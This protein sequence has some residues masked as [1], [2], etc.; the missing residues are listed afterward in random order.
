MIRLLSIV[1]LL[2]ALSSRSQ[3][4]LPKT[5]ADSLWKVWINT[6][7]HDTNRL[8]AIHKYTRE[9]FLYNQPDSALYFAGLQYEFAKKKRLKK[10]MGDALNTLGNAYTIKGELINAISQYSDA[11]ELF[12]QS[13]QKKSV[14]ACLNNIGIIYYNQGDYSRAIDYFTNSMKIKEEI[15]DKKGIASALN[16][17]GGISKNLGDNKRAIDYFTRSLKI[18]EEIGD[19]QQS[20]SC[21]NNIGGIYADEHNYS[22]AK[23]YNNRALKLCE[24][25]GDKKVMAMVLNNIGIVHES[26]ARIIQQKCK[27]SDDGGNTKSA[28]KCYTLSLKLLEEIGDKGGIATTLNN[29]AVIY[30]NYGQYNLSAGYSKKALAFA[31]AAGSII[32]SRDAAHNLYRSYKKAGLRSEALE[33]HELYFLLRDSIKSEESAKEVVRKEFKYNYDKQFVAD[34]IKSAEAKK[35]TDAQLLVKEEQLAREKTQRIALYGGVALLVI[36]GG[37]MYNRFRVTRKQKIIIEQQKLE[38]EKQKTV[39]EDAHTALEEKNKEILDSIHYARRIQ[40]SL[41]P[42]EKYIQRKLNEFKN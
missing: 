11:L 42:K 39:V 21:L 4:S 37:F 8:K 25:L 15:G 34:S 17:I 10:Q 18:L 31:G 40:Q 41:L 29:M 6:T 24:E 26:E 20:I 33:M 3:T 36:F 13:G 9:G 38:V 19:K 14:A 2:L 23:E 22:L 16:N 27:C 32:Q 30:E 7:Q 1:I 5:V 28:I 35:L 12:K